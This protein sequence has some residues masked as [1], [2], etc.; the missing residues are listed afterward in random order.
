MPIRITGMNSGLDTESI[1]TELVKAKSVKK[2]SLV[3]AQTKL[4]WKQDAW[5]EL[6]AKVYALY[7]KTLSNMRLSS[8]YT[9]KTTKVSNSTAAT[10]L[11]G[12]S[13][14][15]GVQTLK[16]NQLAKTGYLTGAELQQDGKK[17]EHKST[18]KLTELGVTEGSELEL[19]VGDTSTKITVDKD[20]TIGDFVSTLKK[21]GL[22]A[23]FDEKNQRFFISAKESG[24]KADFSLTA[25]DAN[26]MNAMKIMGISASLADD[27]ATFNEY[28]KYCKEVKTTLDNG[29][30]SITYEVDKEKRKTIILAAREERIKK[31]GEAVKELEEVEAKLQTYTDKYKDDKTFASTS[32]EDME[33]ELASMKEKLEKTVKFENDE[34]DKLEKDIQDLE[35]K[36]ADKREVTN[37]ETT[38][39]ELNVIIDAN[40]DYL[41]VERDSN[42]KVVL[43]E[44]GKAV[45][46]FFEGKEQDFK[47]VTTKEEAAKAEF[48]ARVL[49]GE[50]TSSGATRIAGQ[51]SEILLNG[52]TFK[53]EG[54]TFEINGLTITAHAETEE[55]FTLTTEDDTDGIYD[56]IKGFL[57]EYNELIN[58]MDK[59]YNA[60]SSKGYE[61]LT[62]EEKEAMSEKD[63]EKWEE[64]IKN[65]LLRRDSTLN[66]VASA[67]KE[68]MM[69]GVAMKDGSQVYL[70]DF[71]IGTLG[72]FT[73]KDNEKNAY[74]IDGDPDDASTMTN[75]DKLKAAIATDPDKVVE[76][77][78]TLTKNLY[79]KIGDLMKKT[80]YSSSFTLYDDV[81]MKDEYN[82][83]KSKI[84][85]QEQKITDY[86]DRYYKKFSAMETALA[87]LQSKESAVSGL[88]NI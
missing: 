1:I 17:A 39:S 38:K 23:N 52:A 36:V 37:L 60:D 32:L 26:G 41:Q 40:D 71:G 59:L 5:K 33:K 22:N 81:A 43:D 15:N 44:E 74:H 19:K 55:E 61:P 46:S 69:R 6:N 73:A 18:T 88:F 85:K 65:S 8:D 48:A 78:S 11:T 31:F 56:M 28:F 76:F 53:S 30:E 24:A 63:I 84:S 20:M 68:V 77:F 82:D 50:F 13:A 34:K 16:I 45:V 83:Y 25:K 2:D 27:D 64:K 29:E 54:N 67:M 75:T 80:E 12:S 49:N 51:D 70:S 87:K 57:K 58:E 14:V 86:E 72:Y 4:E 10:V 47:V 35:V 62:D 79:E 7:S 42:G 9:K 3:K 66:T 21:A